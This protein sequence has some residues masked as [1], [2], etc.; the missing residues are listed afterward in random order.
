MLGVKKFL[1][2][3]E[4]FLVNESLNEYIPT[5]TLEET[6]IY[7]LAHSNLNNSAAVMDGMIMRCF[8]TALLHKSRQTKCIK[9]SLQLKRLAEFIEMKRLD[10]QMTQWKMM[11]IG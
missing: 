11:K 10:F 5:L 8:E 9:E 6:P 3:T 4:T 7:K 1:N 2:K